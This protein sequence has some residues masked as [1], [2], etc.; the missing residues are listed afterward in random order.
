[1]NAPVGSLGLQSGGAFAAARFGFVSRPGRS[2]FG[3]QSS[4]T[5]RGDRQRVGAPSFDRQHR[6]GHDRPVVPQG[7]GSATGWFGIGFHAGKFSPD[8][9]PANPSQKGLEGGTRRGH[10][11]R[12]RSYTDYPATAPSGEF[13]LGVRTCPLLYAVS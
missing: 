6:A 7:Q 5:R 8:K 10:S 11:A 1:M 4:T 9:L 3:V 13:T 12:V 2:S